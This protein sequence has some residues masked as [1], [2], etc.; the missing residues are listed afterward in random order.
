MYLEIVNMTGFYVGMQKLRQKFV[1]IIY[2]Q[3]LNGHND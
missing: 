3:H 2:M 1:R